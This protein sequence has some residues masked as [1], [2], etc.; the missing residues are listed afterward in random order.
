MP[1]VDVPDRLAPPL[2]ACVDAKNKPKVAPFFVKSC[3]AAGI[4]FTEDFNK[5]G[6]REG[7]GYYHFTVKNGVRDSASRAL[8]GDI[9]M[10][11]DVRTNLDILTGAHVTRV[12]IEGRQPVSKTV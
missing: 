12:L 2:L 6:E 10:G 5:P 4:N 7:V 3:K 8:L 11:K 9:I 1:L